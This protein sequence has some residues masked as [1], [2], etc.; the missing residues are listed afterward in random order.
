MLV[1]PPGVGT[2][3]RM[4]NAPTLL[5]ILAALVVA[6]QPPPNDAAPAGAAG[7]TEADRVEWTEYN[8]DIDAELRVGMT[9]R[10]A[11]EGDGGVAGAYYYAKYCRD[12]RL[13]GTVEGRRISLREYDEKG[14]QTGRFEGEFVKK[15]PRR[16]YGGDGSGDRELVRSV[17]VGTWS[18]P[19]GSGERPFYLIQRRVTTT[20]PG[21]NRYHIAGFTD[22]AATEAFVARFRTAALERDREA[23]AD[24]VR[25]PIEVTIDGKRRTIKDRGEL[26]RRFDAV[27][28]DAYLDRLREG[29][30]LHLFVKYSG[31]MLGRG[32]VWFAP[33]REPGPDGEVV[34]VVIS[35]NNAGMKAPVWT[36]KPA[37]R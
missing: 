37:P 15:D 13:E 7:G 9:L 16:H 33:S 28:T 10:F 30:P 22:D 19:D 14:R 31:V 26:V 18:K 12:I 29:Y 17:I 36:V 5:G 34:P 2:L 24:M 20:R 3:T 25:Y 8:G 23:V 6:P 1:V 27:F 32:E 11:G 4:V 35:I 21:E